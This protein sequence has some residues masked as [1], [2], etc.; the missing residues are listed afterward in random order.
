[1]LPCRLVLGTMVK[2]LSL[3]SSIALLRKRD[4][5]TFSRGRQVD[6]FTK[7]GAS[8]RRCAGLRLAQQPGFC[9][10]VPISYANDACHN[11]LRASKYF[12]LM[13]MCKGTANIVQAAVPCL[14]LACNLCVAATQ[15]EINIAK[16]GLRMDPGSQCISN[17]HESPHYS[18]AAARQLRHSLT[19]AI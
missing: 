4:W 3:D 18:H 12:V 6:H 2:T 11:H 15:F 17:T 19:E 8:D 1:L 10:E 9:C 5:K 16:I 14:R 13:R 7:L